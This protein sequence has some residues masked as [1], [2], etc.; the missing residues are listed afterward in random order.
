[1]GA[2]GDLAD[3]GRYVGSPGYQGRNEDR[4]DRIGGICSQK[5]A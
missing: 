3:R 4:D 1:M 2:F 5:N